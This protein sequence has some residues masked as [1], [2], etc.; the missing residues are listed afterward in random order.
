MSGE[1]KA[2]VFDAS[3]AHQARVYDYLLGGKDNYEA[4]RTA[5]VAWLEIDPD[6]AFTAQ[7]NASDLAARRQAL[8]EAAAEEQRRLH[9]FEVELS[10]L[11]IERAAVCD[12]CRRGRLDRAGNLIFAEFSSGKRGSGNNIDARSLRAERQRDRTQDGSSR[13]NVDLERLLG[14]T[15][16][17]NL[18]KIKIPF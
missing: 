7:A 9:R 5:V 1:S 3:V 14:K 17:G 13:L 8:T 11:E 18:D 6:L 4:D 15:D 2:P 16:F 10:E 12:V